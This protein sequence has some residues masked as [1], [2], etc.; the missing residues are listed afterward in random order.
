LSEHYFKV[1]ESLTLKHNI[2]NLKIFQ[3]S[4]LLASEPNL[5]IKALSY[6][7]A[8]LGNRLARRGL[9]VDAEN[10][11]LL[12]LKLNPNNNENPSHFCLAIF[13]DL[14]NRDQEAQSEAK[15]ALQM[16]AHFL[17]KVQKMQ[18]SY[19]NS[20]YDFMNPEMLIIM[21]GLEQMLRDIILYGTLSVDAKKSKLFD[22]TDFVIMVSILGDPEMNTIRDKFT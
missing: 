10:S 7:L 11:F 12:S 19:P 16:L 3:D 22:R 1:L 14:T 8:V 9:L 4:Q 5:I 15:L 17:T 13:Y 18:E 20:S 6:S 21:G 2:L